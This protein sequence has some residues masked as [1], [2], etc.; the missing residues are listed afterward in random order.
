MTD[1]FF[2]IRYEF[3]RAYAHD[4]HEVIAGRSIGR[5]NKRTEFE[6]DCL[7]AC[8]LHGCGSCDS[9]DFIKKLVDIGTSDDSPPTIYVDYQQALFQAI[10]SKN[11]ETQDA[12]K[13]IINYCHA[14][15]NKLI[16]SQNQDGQTPITDACFV[17]LKTVK[18]LEELGAKLNQVGKY[19]QNGMMNAATK[20]HNDIIEYLHTKNNQLIHDQDC[21]G[22]TALIIAIKY[23]QLETVKLLLKLG[24]KIDQTDELMEGQNGMFYAVD[25]DSDEKREIIRVL[26]S[27][28]KSLINST[29]EEG[30]TVLEKAREYGFQKTIDLVL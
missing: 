7:K 23:G 21:I 10:S 24:A 2:P 3:E 4:C 27:E 25:H 26:H 20:G 28:D 18:I 1:D 6:N 29:N 12:K 22:D 15:D 14:M 19:D 11:E 30:K 5:R 8:K 16:H 13:E 9:T 17:D